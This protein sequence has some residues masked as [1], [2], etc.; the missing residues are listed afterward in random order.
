[1][2]WNISTIRL[3]IHILQNYQNNSDF[4]SFTRLDQIAMAP[5]AGRVSGNLLIQEKATVSNNISNNQTTQLNSEVRN[6][7]LLNTMFKVS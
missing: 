3:S 6:R 4:H 2:P 7:N 5:E 1:M